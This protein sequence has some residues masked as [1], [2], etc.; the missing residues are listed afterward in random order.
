[1]YLFLN[2]YFFNFEKLSSKLDLSIK[3][4]QLLLLNEDSQENVTEK[5]LSA[6]WWSFISTESIQ[7]FSYDSGGTVLSFMNLE[8]RELR[9][10][11]NN[12]WEQR[13]VECFERQKAFRPMRLDIKLIFYVNRTL[14]KR[15]RMIKVIDLQ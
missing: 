13:H 4:K 7:Y 3:R 10:R 8:L 12:G 5:N 2:N 6:L 1:M 11:Y 14:K 9:L 15:L